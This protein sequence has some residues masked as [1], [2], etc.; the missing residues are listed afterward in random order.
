MCWGRGALFNVC[1]L[2]VDEAEDMDDDAKEADI[3]P[4]ASHPASSDIKKELR[5]PEKRM[6]SG[7]ANGNGTQDTEQEVAIKSGKMRKAV[8]DDSD[9]D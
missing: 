3:A 7:N 4:D 6:H 2:M 8:I 9:D 5:K 1:L